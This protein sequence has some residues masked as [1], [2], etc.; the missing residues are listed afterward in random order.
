METFIIALIAGAI[1]GF[2]ASFLDSAYY[3]WKLNRLVRKTL[4]NLDDGGEDA[5]AWDWED[6]LIDE[7]KV[8]K[9]KVEPVKKKTTTKKATTSKA[10]GKT[11]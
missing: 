1:G 4:K 6:E 9:T 3:S 2:L 8:T 11:K 5:F 10:K 7:Y